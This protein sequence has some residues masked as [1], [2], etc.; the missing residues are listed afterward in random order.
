MFIISPETFSYY[1][2]LEVAWEKLEK[3]ITLD[4]NDKKVIIAT[5]REKISEFKK[6]TNVS[7]NNYSY[8]GK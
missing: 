6:L 7:G 5:I 3:G 8:A 2:N 4:E 1:T